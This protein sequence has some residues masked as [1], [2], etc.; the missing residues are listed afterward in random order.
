ML[1]YHNMIYIYIYTWIFTILNPYIV[2]GKSCCYIVFKH[3]S[4]WHLKIP[5][6]SVGPIVWAKAP[7]R[8]SSSVGHVPA[9]LSTEVH[10]PKCIHLWY[11]YIYLWYRFQHTTS[12]SNGPHV[13][14]S[15]MISLPRKM[16]WWGPKR[17]NR[18]VPNVTPLITI[19]PSKIQLSMD[20]LK[21]KFTG[22]NRCSH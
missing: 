4:S 20:W 10:P 2:V 15:T 3:W 21:G 6:L 22:N 5:P 16:G 1:A 9:E 14:E 18:G 13:D 7:C 17:S 8:C 19:K 11:I 12:E